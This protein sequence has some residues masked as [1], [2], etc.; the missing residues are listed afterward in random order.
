[1][2][3]RWKNSCRDV[4][5]DTIAALNTDHYPVWCTHKIR[6]KRQRPHEQ[7]V[8]WDL[9][10]NDDQK[11]RFN[12]AF[13][14]LL[15]FS[16]TDD[17]EEHQKLDDAFNSAAKMALK[18]KSAVI[19]KPWITEDTLKLIKQ[20]HWF[21]QNGKWCEYKE[22]QKEVRKAVKTDWQR[23][24]QEITD[25]DLDVRDKWLGIKYIKRK[26]APKLYERANLEGYAI[27]FK[28]HA[29]AAA[30]YLETK[31][32]GNTECNTSEEKHQTMANT[33]ELNIA[34]GLFNLSELSAI[35]TKLK[36]NKATGPDDIPIEF[37]KWLHDDNRQKVLNLINFWWDQSIFPVEKLKAH[38]ASIYK[39]GD[40][41]KQENYRPI[42]LLNSIYK[43]YA[44]MIQIR[45]ADGIDGHLQQTQYGFR[46]ARSTSTPLACVRRLLEKA[47]AS[48]DPMFLVFLDWEKAFDRVKQDKLFEAL[49]R[50]NIPSHFVNVIRSLYNNPQFSV[51]MGSQQSTWR[52]QSTG[53]RQGCPLSP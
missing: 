4:A 46:K 22:K 11:Q 9:D 35:I 19:K 41:K 42:S 38:I 12:E 31:Q 47:E 28:Q 14:S 37:F 20:K 8:S 23:W 2:N 7:R 5:S 51:R 50:M 21:E 40:P 52:K 6:Y 34:C 27:N 32:W 53:I 25:K 33:T 1:M 16:P 29:S 10:V 15:D 18:P 49:E 30:D 3:S 44:G 26:R 45:L 17:R 13:D 48:Q 24:L 43:L 39:K 36:R